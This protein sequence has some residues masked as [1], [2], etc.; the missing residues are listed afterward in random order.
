[1]RKPRLHRDR[2]RANISV[3]D[4]DTGASLG[5]LLDLSPAGLR[6]AGRGSP[7]R[8]TSRTLR[9]ELPV[10]VGEHRAVIVPVECRWFEHQSGNR[11]QA[12]YRLGAVADAELT[13]LEHL[14]TWYA[15]S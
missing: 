11:W 12:G 14:M 10:R 9:L 4:A 7:V 6:V 2:L 1:M 5:H 8:E 3:F 13:V 15:D